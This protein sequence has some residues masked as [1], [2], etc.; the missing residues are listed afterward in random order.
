MTAVLEGILTYFLLCRKAWAQYGRTRWM[1]RQERGLRSQTKY[2]RWWDQEGIDFEGGGVGGVGGD[3]YVG[4][5]RGGGGWK[6]GPS[7]YIDLDG[8]KYQLIT[9]DTYTSV[10]LSCALGWN[11]VTRL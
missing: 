7:R 8:A 6:G 1:L 11:F 2:W 4:A 10:P 3:G 5:G 9:I